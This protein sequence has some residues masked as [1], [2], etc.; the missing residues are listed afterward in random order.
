METTEENEHGHLNEILTTDELSQIPN[1]S[2]KKLQSYFNDKFEE[3]LTAKA[4]FE[5]SRQNLGEIFILFF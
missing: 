3:Y 1:S 5:T 4:I 2:L